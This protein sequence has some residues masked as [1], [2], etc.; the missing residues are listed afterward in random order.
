MLCQRV[1]I[2]V[3]VDSETPYTQHLSLLKKKLNLTEETICRTLR[4]S[5]SVRKKKAS[6][7]R[8]K[9][10]NEDIDG[11][12]SDKTALERGKA[13]SVLNRPHRYD[14]KTMPLKAKN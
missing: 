6:E 12:A 4:Q 5:W 8:V 13:I 11:F 14:G 2:R 3:R 1:V 7:E 10:K 9:A